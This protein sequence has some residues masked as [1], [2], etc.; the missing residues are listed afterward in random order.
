[1]L[2]KELQTILCQ[3]SELTDN[4]IMIIQMLEEVCIEYWDED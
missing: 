4:L 3:L 1:M 2:K